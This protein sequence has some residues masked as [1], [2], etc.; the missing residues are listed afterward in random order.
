MNLSDVKDVPEQ[1]EGRC[2]RVTLLVTIWRPRC[3]YVNASGHGFGDV[4]V[5]TIMSICAFPGIIG[6]AAQR[7]R[8][9]IRRAC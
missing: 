5:R 6:V 4:S 9:V 2:C 8:N 7:G 3:G 1:L